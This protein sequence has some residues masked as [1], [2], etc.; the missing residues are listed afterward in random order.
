MANPDVIGIDTFAQNLDTVLSNII[1]KIQQQQATATLPL[2]VN[3]DWIIRHVQDQIPPDGYTIAPINIPGSSQ[4]LGNFNTFPRELRDIIFAECLASG[5]PQFL[6]CS[7]AM[8]EEGM[9]QIW[10]KGVYRMNFGDT[11]R[12]NV[13]SSATMATGA[14]QYLQPTQQIAERIQHLRIRSKRSIF[15]SLI[16]WSGIDF[17]ALRQFGGSEVRRKSCTILLVVGYDGFYQL[18]VEVV[19][20][21]ETLVGFERVDLRVVDQFPK[22]L[23]SYARLPTSA[24]KYIYFGDLL[25][26][27]LGHSSMERDEEG[28]YVRFHPRQYVS[29][30]SQELL[31]R[32]GAPLFGLE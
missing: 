14:P 15:G 30:H 21:L 13:V 32:E 18:G 9:S 20:A 12:L 28:Y 27:S 22:D 17:D 11:L 25:G 10:E 7:R 1:H 6:A 16:K 29:E 24:R 19:R 4:G 26:R 23:P 8:R 5:Y 3:R 2:Q 31:A